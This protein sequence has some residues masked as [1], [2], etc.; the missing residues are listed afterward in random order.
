[1]K[2]FLIPV[3]VLVLV[4]CQKNNETTNTD[5]VSAMLNLP[6]S[7]F[8]YEN[9]NFPQHLLEP[10]VLNADNTPLNNNVT[11]NGATLGRVLFYD[12]NLSKNKTVSCASCHKQELGFSDDLIL[13]DGFDKGKTGRHS[14]GLT[15]ARFYQNGRFFWDERAAT[16]ENQVL[17]PIQDPV[18]MGLTLD[19]LVERISNLDYY[20][21]LFENAFNSTEINEEKIARALAQFVRSMVSYETKYDVGRVQANTPVE[22]FSNFTQ[23][24][25]MGKQIFFN[26]NLG[27]CAGCHGSE[28]F[29]SPGPRSNGLDLTIT[30]GGVGAEN[31]NQNQEGKFKAPSLRNVAIRA[32]FMHDG[33]FSTL[34]QVVEH[35]NSGVQASPNLDNILRDPNTGLPKKLNLN[36]NQKAALVAFLNTLTDD[37]MVTDEKFADPFWD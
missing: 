10:N 14:M 26:P 20:P 22:P 15:M 8:N 29:I 18:E 12:K 4:S 16:L 28:A 19:T 6:E 21:E 3:F 24:E 37:N 11:D 36:T 1:M 13:S 9:P 2:K 30:D 7:P 34:E 25:N 31:G 5:P 17:M 32:P 23:Q 33:R 27:S 35:Y